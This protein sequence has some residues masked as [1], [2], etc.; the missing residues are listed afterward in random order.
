[1]KKTGVR[2]SKQKIS[3]IALL[4]AERMVAEYKPKVK[5]HTKKLKEINQ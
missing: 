4:A 2:K 3:F 1:M 5:Y